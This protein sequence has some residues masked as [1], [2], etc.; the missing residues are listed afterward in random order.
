MTPDV[1]RNPEAA[2]KGSEADCRSVLASLLIGSPSAGRRFRDVR[3]SQLAGPGASLAVTRPGKEEEERR[4][5][6]GVAR[7]SPGL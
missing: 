1:V 6:W 7:G 2:R 3:T 4:D 5:V